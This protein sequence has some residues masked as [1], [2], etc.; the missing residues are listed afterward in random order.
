[1]A[2]GAIDNGKPGARLYSDLALLDGKEFLGRRAARKAA[3]I[4]PA[5][6]SRGTAA[7]A[8]LNNV[9]LITT[10]ISFNWQ[11]ALVGVAPQASA[12]SGLMGVFAALVKRC[13]FRHPAY[14]WFL[15]APFIK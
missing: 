5:G 12:P 10:F 15:I 9:G 6:G 11:L 13:F 8:A 7:V 1:M 14:L 4:F 3:G 2:A